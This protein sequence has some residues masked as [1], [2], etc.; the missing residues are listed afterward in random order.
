VWWAGL[1]GGKGTAGRGRRA[2]KTRVG[3]AGHEEDG[4]CNRTDQI[5]RAQVQKQAPKRSNF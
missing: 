4:G 5:I 3:Q 2:R 1:A